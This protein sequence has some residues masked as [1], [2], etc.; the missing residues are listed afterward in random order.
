MVEVRKGRSKMTLR[1]VHLGGAAALVVALTASG[2]VFA[3]AGNSGEHYH[4]ASRGVFASADWSASDASGTTFG[5]V[6]VSRRST[7]EAGGASL[8]FDVTRCDPSD[9]CVSEHGW[10]DIPAGALT[11]NAQSGLQL[12]ANTAAIP[13]FFNSGAGGLVAVD[14]R[15]DGLVV[16]TS[17]GSYTRRG[18]GYS[19]RRRGT[20]TSQS[21]QVSG[22]V[23]GVPIGPTAAATIGSRRLVEVDF[24]RER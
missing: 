8:S 18:E 1:M 9:N 11:G 10:G 3:N 13:G 2:P 19:E 14:W 23:L 6:T 21:A 15:K 7:D 12:S 24:Y 5:W 22:A 16:E 4:F 17:S 20:S